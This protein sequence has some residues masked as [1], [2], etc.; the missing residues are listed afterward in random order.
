MESSLFSCG[1]LYPEEQIVYDTIIVFIREGSRWR[2]EESEHIKFE[3]VWDS[4]AYRCYNFL[5]TSP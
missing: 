2:H 5:S 3:H 4:A 1:R